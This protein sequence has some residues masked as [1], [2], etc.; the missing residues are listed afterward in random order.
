MQGLSDDADIN[1]EDA[2]VVRRGQELL[3]LALN[4]THA[5]GGS[6]MVGVIYSAIKKYP[7]ACS[8]QARRNV[9]SSLQVCLHRESGH[10]DARSADRV[11]EVKPGASRCVGRNS[12]QIYTRWHGTTGVA[13]GDTLSPP[14]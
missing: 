5:I 3:H 2:E 12:I 1:S 8:P 9:V 6:H 11:R 4:K 14:A 7:G 13:P 10:A